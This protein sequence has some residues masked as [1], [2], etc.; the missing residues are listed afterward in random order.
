MAGRKNNF[1][2]ISYFLSVFVLIVFCFFVKGNSA[3]AACDI[4]D[5]DFRSSVPYPSNNFTAPGNEPFVYLDIDTQDC[6]GESITL[7]VS[8]VTSFFMIEEYLDLDNFDNIQIDVTEPNFTIQAK[9]TA[10]K[11]SAA[12]GGWDCIYIIRTWDEGGEE[13][14]E[15]SEEES[16]Q[17][18]CYGT[19]TC[20]GDTNLFEAP[21]IRI[22]DTFPPDSVSEDDQ[23]SDQ[24]I[25]P[26]I[27]GGYGPLDESYLAPLP[28]LSNATPPENRLKGFLQGLFQVLIIIAGILAV[29]MIVIGAITYLSTDAF[30]G[31][32]EGKEM[33]LN[34]VFGLILA[35]GGWIII[36]TINPNLASTLSI[37]IPKV[38]VDA[39]QEEWQ[40]GNAPAGT[41]IAEGITLNNQ[42]I[43]QGGTW[44]SD[45]AQ[46]QAL[47][48]EGINVW[49]SGDANQADGVADCTEGAGT[50]NCTSVYFEGAGAG[51]IQ[52][53]I[54]FKNACSCDVT[55][56]GGS[57][58][59]LHTTHGPNK[60]V[61]D[62]NITPS[63]NAYLRGLPGGPAPGNDFPTGQSITILGVGKFKAEG[64]GDNSNTTGD[65]WHVRFY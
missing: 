43:T 14:W 24:N 10:E 15:N 38:H 58:A 13:I 53:I 65:H 52:D 55:I 60:K 4:V 61:V 40:N 64:A 3:Q 34:A 35:L 23:Y 48:A 27:S 25:P 20:E 6:V 28:G 32:S 39:P 56:T 47:D 7:S 62:M 18:D 9:A 12:Y 33:M 45:A 31:K 49:S 36:N 21:W 2:K 42:P 16:L 59:W 51:V 26:F 1:Q 29:I 41:D 8:A 63:L 57:E 5:A 19:F 54:D 22:P 37:T 50:P 17:Y 44:P 11:C 46:R 30:S